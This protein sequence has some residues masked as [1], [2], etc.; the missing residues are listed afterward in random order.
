MHT[1]FSRDFWAPGQ[2]G[3]G[4]IS[5]FDLLPRSKFTC[6]IITYPD[7]VNLPESPQCFSARSTFLQL[8][9]LVGCQLIS[10]SEKPMAYLAGASTSWKPLGPAPS[11]HW[12]F[13]RYSKLARQKCPGVSKTWIAVDTRRPYLFPMT[14]AQVVPWQ[15]VR[16]FGWKHLGNEWERYP[17]NLESPSECA[18]WKL[19]PVSRHL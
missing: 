13:R 12:V 7:T 11:L 19:V 14:T 2:S 5:K 15:F 16:I 1:V 10:C 6:T 17:L 4:H 8:L 18:L 3:P 9:N